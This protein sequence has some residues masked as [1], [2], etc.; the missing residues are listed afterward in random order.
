MKQKLTGSAYLL[1][2]T[3]IWGS[4]FV[5]QSLGM[6]HVGPF[7][8]QA[9]R[10][11]MAAVGLLALIA[12]ADL[13]KRDGSN[14]FRRF[15]RKKLWLG[16]LLSGG[17]LCLAVNLQQFGI[18]YTSAG[19]SAFFTAMYIIFVP[20]IG[21]F[22]RRKPSPLIP[23]CVILAVLGLYFL[24]YDGRSPVNFADLCLLLCALA[25]AAQ[26]TVIDRFAPDVDALRLNCLQSAVCALGS[27]VIMLFTETPTTD[28]IRG[29]WWSMCYA[30]FLSMGIAYSLQILGQKRLE[31]AAASLIMSLESVF[32]AVCGYL[33]LR[34]SLSERELTG[35]LLVFLAVLLS[36]LPIPT[37]EITGC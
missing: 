30:G 13:G 25:F 9:I 14:F 36:Q 19:K 29:S 28:G 31:P 20:I 33:F 34:E 17:I 2:A 16:G 11:T 5:A 6:D 32:A 21:I 18:L 4:A 37:K 3:V 22:L 12:I 15:A 26:I 7:T 27:A 8:F 1:L 23:L 24:S 10:C 35:C